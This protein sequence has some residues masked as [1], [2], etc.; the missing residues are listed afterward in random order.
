MTLKDIAE[1]NEAVRLSVLSRIYEATQAHTGAMVDPAK[2]RPF[3]NC[4]D[5]EYQRALLYLH[6]EGLIKALLTASR[7]WQEVIK[8]RLEH[9]GVKELERIVRTPTQPT[10]HFSIQVVQHFHKEVGAAQVGTNSA[11]V[12]S[13]GKTS[14]PD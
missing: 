7:G 5:E 6:H 12:S 8:F 11:H 1:R 2:L 10:E 13:P 9:R 4:T 3:I 14:P